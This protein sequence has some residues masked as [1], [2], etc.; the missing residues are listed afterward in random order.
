MS[1]QPDPPNAAPTRRRWRIVAL[2]AVVLVAVVL[3]AV[4]VIGG[5]AAQR[6]LASEAALEFLA[7]E[8]TA[9]SGGR[10]AIEGAEGSLASTMRLQ[11]LTYRDPPL[12]IVAEDVALDWSPSA[13]WS[14]A[15][16]V[17]RLDARRVTVTPA[18][19]TEPT[20]LPATLALPFAVTIKRASVDELVY[21]G[22]SPQR[23]ERIAFGYAGDINGHRISALKLAVDGV[24]LDVDASIAASAPFI[25]D[26]NLRAVGDERWR[27]ATIGAELSGRLDAIDAIV[28]GAL[29]TTTLSGSARLLLFDAATLAK[30]KLDLAEVDLA[31]F[32][33][34][35]PPTRIAGHVDL[36]LAVDGRVEGTID[37]ANALAG[38][39]DAARLPIA[40]ARSRFAVA[41]STLTLD[42]LDAQ[43]GPTGG[44]VR[45]SPRIPLAEGD[46]ASEFELV[47]EALDLKRLHRALQQTSLS[48]PLRVRVDRGG[49]RFE[50]TLTQSGIALDFAA[51]HRGDIVDVP[52]FRA[53]SPG[54]ELVG[55]GSFRTAAPR[56][57]EAVATA[58]RFDPSQFGDLPAAML[59]GEVKVTGRLVPAWQADVDVAIAPTSRIAD[60]PL[61]GDLRARISADSVEDARIDVK[62]AGATLKAIGSAGR[63]PGRIDFTFDVP[64]AAATLAPL[65][66]RV[67]ATLRTLTGRLHGKG[68]LS[69]ALDDPALTAE[70]RAESA[71]L[72]GVTVGKLELR[73]EMGARANDRKM[74]WRATAREV[75]TPA[76][77]LASIA[78]TLDGTPA[79]H[80]LTVATKGV[81]LDADL[82]L[83][84][85]LA[86]GRWAG[87]VTRMEN[88]GAYAAALAAPATLDIAA[89]SVAVG[90]ARFKFADGE[91]R[92]A[93]FRWDDGRITSEDA[94]DSLPVA[95]VARMVGAKLPF[96]STLVV[97]GEWRVVAS[98]GLNGTLT[99]R[100][101]RGDLYT[102]DERN[103][104][105]NGIA[106]GLARVDVTASLVDDALEAS[107]DV[108]GQRLGT[109][110]GTLTVDRDPGATRGRIGP[111]APVRGTLTAS[112]PSLAPWQPL[113]GTAALVE[114]RVRADLAAS[115][116]L[117]EVRV[118]GELSADSLRLDAPQY[119]LHWRD[120]KLRARLTD[121]ALQLDE[122]SFAGGDGRFHADGS[123]G[124]AGKTPGEDSETR[125]ETRIKWRA[126]KLRATNRPDLKLVLT[127]NG[128]LSFADHQLLLSGAVKVDEGVV[129]FERQQGSRLG[130]D[131]VVKGRP[132]RVEP[133]AGT[134]AIPVGLELA[135]DLGPSLAVSGEGLQARAAGKINVRAAPG[136]AINA[137][138]TIRAVNG[139][140]FAFGQRLV[141]DRGRLIFD[142]PITNPALD[143]VALRRNLAVEAGVRVSGT[144]RVP[145]VELTSEPPVPDGEK[146][147]WL[148][149]G[150]GLDRTSAADAAALQAAAATIF[151]NGRIP[152]GT[153]LAQ[154]VGLDDISVRSSS[155][156]AAADANGGVGN[157]VVA[158]GKRL[159]D[160][161]YIVYE[162]GLSVANNALRIEFALTRSITL[163]AEAG[164]ISGVGIYYRRSFQ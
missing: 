31:H 164:L 34:A 110:A 111:Q 152:L 8:L 85:G 106:L 52:R 119:G 149:L 28:A 46:D 39:F 6:W 88:R 58:T 134:N 126:D 109:L 47:V 64:D 76:G 142:G 78:A 3:A 4:L 21:D 23:I 157:Q 102:R 62:F 158:V 154:A 10:I 159:S 135:V 140:F 35:L 153:T 94:L 127:G 11:R 50:G 105:A 48:G 17:N 38:G 56:A 145:H 118:T 98:P 37:A 121:G 68:A 125:I 22:G 138:G 117:A 74:S 24:T 53:R 114:G 71:T 148:V 161:L 143:I 131:V 26:G 124:R 25:I 2:V 104:A 116:T 133:V 129:D 15:L 83:E 144:V 51:T 44:R 123:I 19:S 9:R 29:G 132:R 162:Q 87:Q 72:S 137:K 141:I 150:Q 82:R 66:D 7:A 79:R 36:R 73:G 151:G 13:L 33:A 54:G 122:F 112:L 92:V 63:R 59:D 95:S 86:D 14:K 32:E 27:Q 5:I 115:G 67:P 49:Q 147:S 42:G 12:T 120:G 160:R 128:Q 40:T 113:I 108:D 65:R 41:D 77:K 163:R 16:A 100:K 43:P 155:S 84:G 30:A 93:G 146:L 97:G 55:R 107:V 103:P 80:A 99:L 60:A 101:Q 89:R 57:F 96:N 18:P 69:G 70:A 91:V 1:P 61:R 45:G 75:E 20:T 139:T 90:T 136:G 81:N 130:D 156:S